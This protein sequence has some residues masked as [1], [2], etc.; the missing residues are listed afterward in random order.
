MG[1]DVVEMLLAHPQNYCFDKHVLM[2]VLWLLHMMERRPCLQ[3]ERKLLHSFVLDS[4]TCMY[5][6]VGVI[7]Y[8]GA[9][10][11]IAK[12]VSGPN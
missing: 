2:T 6:A 12:K 1:N 3:E 11:D 4:H 5:A 7:V 10:R 9:V 8:N